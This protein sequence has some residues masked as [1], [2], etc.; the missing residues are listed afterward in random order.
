MKPSTLKA[1]EA[2][3]LASKRGLDRAQKDPEDRT[4]ELLSRML[5]EITSKPHIK[6]DK[7]DRG[8]V[9]PRGEKGESITGPRGQKGEP[10][11]D[12][13]DGNKGDPGQNGNA[14]PQEIRDIAEAEVNVHEKVFDHRLLHDKKVL[15]PLELDVSSIAEGK[16]FQ[17]Q[18]GKI[19]CIDLPKNDQSSLPYLVSQGVS[20]VRSFSVTANTELDAMG[21]YVIDA[22]AGNVTITVPSASGR[23]NHWFELIRID[24]SANTVTI[25]PTGSETMSG[26]TTYQLINQ[27]STVT[28]FAYSSNYLMRHI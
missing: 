1:L 20:N 9:G 12:G 3:S 25:T 26:L 15:G 7:G 17:V 19:V 6:G 10:G 8:M 11:R 2:F 27:W 16:I 14:D 5:S 28:L 13:R 24:S 18:G 22:S 23:E 21:M 4:V